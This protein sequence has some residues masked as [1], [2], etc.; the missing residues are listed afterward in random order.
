MVSCQAP[1]DRQ[2][3]HGRD[4]L[5]RFLTADYSVHFVADVTELETTVREGQK[6]LLI[7]DDFLTRT[8]LGD[9]P[10]ATDQECLFIFMRYLNRT[11][12]KYLIPTT[13]EYLYREISFLE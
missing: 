8:N 3:H 2:E 1:W 13:R 5:A 6:Q 4:D 10:G 9:A 12:S 7:Y 11:P